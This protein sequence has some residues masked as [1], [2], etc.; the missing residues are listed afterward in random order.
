MD[1][2]SQIEDVDRDVGGSAYRHEEAYFRQLFEGSP[3]AIV[4]ADREGRVLEANN[5]FEKLFQY[6]AAEARGRPIDE[7]VAPPHRIGEADELSERARNGEIIKREVVRRRKDGTLM[8]ASV[9]AYPILMAGEIVGFCGTYRDIT[10][11]RRTQETLNKLSRAVEQSAENIFITDRDGHIEYVN[12]AFEELTEYTSAEV[13]GK[14]P[15]IL[16]SG[17]QDREFYGELW[18]TILS[19][20]VFR[21]TLINRKKSGKLYHEEKV[22]TPVKDGEGSIT[23]FVWTGKDITDRMELEERLLQAQ[24]LEAIGRLA[25]GVA[26]DFNNLLT[27]VIG[28]GQLL[29]TRLGNDEQLC[30]MAKEIIKGGQRGA[31]LARQLLAFSRRQILQPRV[32]DLNA[33]ILNVRDMLER[34][35]PENIE[36]VTQLGATIG[37]VKADPGQIEQVILNLVINAR[38]A[39]PAGGTLTIETDGVDLDDNYES[40]HLV[41]R[42]GHYVMISVSDTGIGMDQE[43]QSHVFEPFFT[44]KDQG[45]SGLGLATVYGIVNQSGGSVWLHSELGHGSTF[46]VYLPRVEEPAEDLPAE[47]QPDACPTG[48]ETVLLVED[49]AQVRAL[50][51]EILRAQGYNV[52]QASGGEEA[53]RIA[54]GKSRNEIDLLVTDVVMPQMSGPEL[55]V[56]L[57]SAGHHTKVLYMSGYTDNWIVHHGVSQGETSFLQKPFTPGLLA[58]KVRDVLDS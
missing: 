15:R 37:R 14:T 3:D 1:R 38:D 51:A 36:L 52:L 41:R 49:N 25:G 58:S 4:M 5:S 56:Q 17:Q 22:I 9:L 57:A 54:R 10:G 45:G 47:G 50:A 39:M 6:T 30:R 7:L 32:I 21:G 34:L 33:V 24:K 27:A 11:D 46:K 26:H 13:I 16:K 35:I 31:A 12:P 23:N 20:K 48:F 29:A 19:G 8:V 28:Y 53:L 44:T 2:G 18:E 40:P 42:R 55:A 43:T